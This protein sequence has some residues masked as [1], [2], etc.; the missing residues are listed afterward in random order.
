MPTTI[1]VRTQTKILLKES[2]V[3]PPFLQF[4]AFYKGVELQ[5]PSGLASLERIVNIQSFWMIVNESNV[6]SERTSK[7]LTLP[8]ENNN[9]YIQ[10]LLEM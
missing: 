9:L 1:M 2:L 4:Q 10:I 6:L 5:L 3:S 7:P 8:H